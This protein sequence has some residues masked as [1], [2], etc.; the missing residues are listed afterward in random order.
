MS[1][2]KIDHSISKGI[3]SRDSVACSSGSAPVMLRRLAG[4][5]AAL[6]ML[7]A[8]RP[9][10]SHTSSKR[11]WRIVNHVAAPCPQ[12]YQLRMPSCTADE[13]AKRRPSASSGLSPFDRE[14]VANLVGRK[15]ARVERE[16]ILQ[17]LR[18]HQG[19]RTRTADR[20]G[21]S[22]RS[23]RDKIRTYRRYGESVPEPGI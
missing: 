9:A 18:S 13:T 6:A 16:F 21:I 22:I 12:G 3:Q 4:T 1:L 10:S 14:C 19:N 8:M 23:L 17:T 2:F 20:L 7:A 5:P 15:L 11:H